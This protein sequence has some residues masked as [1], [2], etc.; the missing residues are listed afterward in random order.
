VWRQFDFAKRCSWFCVRL[1]GQTL[2][3]A[4]Q[5]RKGDDDLFAPADTVLMKGW[6]WK[7]GKSCTLAVSHVF[8][9]CACHHRS[10]GQVVEEAILCA[11]A[12]GVQVLCGQGHDV[13]QGATEA[14]VACVSLA[15][16][17][18]L[19]GGFAT[20]DITSFKRV[21]TEKFNRPHCFAFVTDVRWWYCCGD[22]EGEVRIRWGAVAARG[23]R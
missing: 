23:W 5:P 17:T 1:M 12:N 15:D 7:R 16:S 22:S 2:A 21:P 4:V 18:T 8:S 3:R 9:P 10:N 11:Y 20:V 13:S 6:L 19:Q 14:C